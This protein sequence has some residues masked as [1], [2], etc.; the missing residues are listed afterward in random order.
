MTFR[1]RLAGAG[2]ALVCTFVLV[3]RIEVVELLAVAGFDAVVPELDP[4]P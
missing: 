2:P 4:G 1:E 3:P